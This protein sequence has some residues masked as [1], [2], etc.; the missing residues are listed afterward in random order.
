MKRSKSS[1]TETF[2]DLD[3]LARKALKVA[4]EMPKGAKRIEALKPAT[5]LRLA[6]D[7]RGIEFAPLG[8]PPKERMGPKD[9]KVPDGC[10]LH[11]RCYARSKLQTPR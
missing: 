11:H 4:R 8:R 3:A 7:W 2:H 9:P 1:T 6:A 10:E 5:R